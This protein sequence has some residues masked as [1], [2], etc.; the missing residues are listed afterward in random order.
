[1]G[2]VLTPTLWAFLTYS[3]PLAEI[4]AARTVRQNTGMLTMPMATMVGPMPLPS[5][6]EI[7]IASRMEG[8][9]K[10]MSIRHMMTRSVQ[11]SK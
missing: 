2:Q 6:A 8:K 11:P 4:T 5:T 1:M 7:K 9:A 3:S 10:R